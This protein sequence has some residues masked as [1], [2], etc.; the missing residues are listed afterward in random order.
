VVAK[1]EILPAFDLQAPF[2]SLPR[3]LGLGIGDVGMPRPYLSVTPVRPLP[4]PRLGARLRV[5]IAWAGS[6]G[7]VKNRFRSIPLSSLDPLL[8]L[9]DVEIL[10]LQRGHGQDQLPLH[11]AA[12]RIVDLGSG[13]RD[14]R[15]TAEAITQ[16]D[17][18]VTVDTA[19]AHLAGALGRPTLLL[20]PFDADWRWMTDREDTPWYPTVKLM[21]NDR[22]ASWSGVVE[23]VVSEVRE[24]RPAETPGALL[25]PAQSDAQRHF[26]A[27]VRSHLEG[28]T[29]AARAGYEAAL[30]SDPKLAEAHSNL[31][32]LVRHEDGAEPAIVHFRRALALQPNYAD[33]RNNLGLALMQ[34]GQ[35][36]E[37]VEC[38]RILTLQHPEHGDGLNNLG[39]AL[40]DLGEYEAAIA[41][42]EAAVR[43]QPENPEWLNNLGNVLLQSSRTVEAMSCYQRALAISP[44]YAEAL[45]NLGAA[46]RAKRE[47]ETS[48]PY[49]HRALELQPDYL[50]ALHNLALSL[51]EGAD[52]TG[53]ETVL[54]AAAERNAHDPRYAALLA[55]FLEE[56]ASFA[57]AEAEARS[58]LDRDPTI[59]DTWSVLGVC[60]AEQGD[61][62]E[63]IRCY[64]RAI[65]LDPQCISAHWNLSLAHL[66]LGNY[67][68]GW[69]E[70]E[71]RWKLLFFAFER[72]EPTAPAWAGE[73]LDGKTILLYLEQG[74]GDGLMFLRFARELKRRWDVRVI[75]ETREPLAAVIR[76][77]EYVDDI[78]LHG[79]S[80]PPHD[81]E[82][83][84]LSIPRL[85]HVELDSLPAEPYLIARSRPV[86]RLIEDG[87]ELKVGLV[88]GGRV[89]NPNLARRS[90]ELDSLASLVAT[91]GVRFYS[92][93]KGEPAAALADSPLRDRIV[94]LG[95]ALDDF[96]DTAAAIA[97][98]D[99]VITIDTA[100]AHLAG[101]L[102]KPVWV[103]LMHV[104]D[105]R[106][107]P[108]RADSPWYPSARLFR[109]AEIG[110][111][112]PVLEQVTA[113]LRERAGA[114]AAD[115]V[116]PEV[117]QPAIAAAVTL[118]S[119]SRTADG[120]PRFRVEVPWTRLAT[121]D[122]FAVYQEELTGGVEVDARLFL[123]EDLRDGD[124]LVDVG[125][126]WG[127]VS[128]SAATAPDRSVRVLALVDSNDDAALIRDAAAGAG[129]SG[130]H[131]AHVVDL[132]EPQIEA[133][134]GSLS[135][136]ERVFL[137]VG[138]PDHAPGA[139][140]ACASLIA[141][142]R[143]AGVIWPA[144]APTATEG[145]MQRQR[146]VSETLAAFGFNH[147][148]MDSDENG[149]V[150]SPSRPE[151]ASGTI[152][153]LP[154]QLPETTVDGADEEF[155]AASP[156]QPLVSDPPVP[157]GFDWQLGASS[158]WG[159]YGLNLALHAPAFGV[160][161]RPLHAP[162]L[163]ALTPLQAFALE[164]VLRAGTPAPRRTL[165]ALGN[166]LQGAAIERPSAIA[167]VGVVFFEDTAL[168]RAAV[169]RGRR[170]ERIVT[171]STWNA[172][173]LRAHGLDEVV[174]CLQGIDPTVFHPAPAAGLFS[175]RFVVFSGGKLEY[176]K[177]QD[178]VVAAFRHFQARHPEAVL[179]VAWHNHW[180][181][182]MAEIPLRRH[183]SGVPR[184]DAAGR[185]DTRGWLMANGVPDSAVIDLGL[186]PNGS[187]GQIVREAHVALFPNRCE[188][189]TNLVAMECLA[190]GVP[191]ILSANTGHLD[192]VSDDRCY[193][194]LRQHPA[195]PS[196][197]FRGVDGWGESDVEEM[198]ES[199]ELV[200]QQRADAAARGAA[201]ARFMGRLT[202]RD[203]IGTLLHS[204]ADLL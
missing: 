177:G 182:S 116:T 162:D 118:D 201:A 185:M 132:G 106:W 54:R 25:N 173:V 130:V 76:A 84:L 8:E 26:T 80:A 158:G 78:T 111:W 149:R 31:G 197:T 12:D 37:A 67:A 100:V 164:P 4:Q 33:A 59:A 121:D 20:L 30:E 186:V 152:I 153:S 17:L 157:L 22:G 168:D 14:L 40:R 181:R 144:A 3:L 163:R 95:P 98:L 104:A 190:S 140:M 83:P 113:A 88:W 154:L 145:E 56:S 68:A 60:R 183:V 63:A 71:W 188:G 165:R 124:G 73:S 108:E 48:I 57:A 203:Q 58:V 93:Q 109:Q 112:G 200:Y 79:A 122:G 147:Y 137:R 142:N 191:T 150:L 166:G 5:G 198:V 77:C 146:I 176:R 50:D 155:V 23:G 81:L 180:P 64:E 32:V 47:Y 103:L 159:V 202:W 7:H 46:Y 114:E 143:L 13:F 129:A 123:D 192:L 131:V 96:Q 92:L 156:I 160:L 35:A 87:P 199:L 167:D 101:A 16:L 178:L 74:F 179:M 161:P 6:R 28:D 128:L 184:I 117:V 61:Y 86:E 44:D 27:A 18:V 89:P 195:Q 133:L 135:G 51:P 148:R 102:G 139:L 91:P 141:D 175:D 99:L 115:V 34:T 120:S 119:G 9:A 105:W 151:H 189:G 15:D 174:V 110:A 134:L 62:S 1:G 21:R 55:L 125:A 171:G 10:S 39:V 24:L 69:D 29:A 169:E 36:A 82:I 187:M 41:P 38:F 126:G 170:F 42:L 172:E 11:P 127:F 52:L 136:C 90:L 72:R 70:Y 138:A 49:F 65:E 53:H 45:N 19:V 66:M 85:L 194:L 97:K 94:D 2:L 75:V 196:A 43:L 107:L 204:I 193:P